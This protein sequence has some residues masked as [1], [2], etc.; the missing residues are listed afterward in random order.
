MILFLIFINF[1]E[2]YIVL[3]TK[4]NILSIIKIVK[5][6]LYFLVFKYQ[7]NAVKNFYILK[8]T[9]PFYIKGGL[10]L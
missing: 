9:E 1:F 2:F 10:F 5:T 8:S 3:L 7:K 6:N 4:N